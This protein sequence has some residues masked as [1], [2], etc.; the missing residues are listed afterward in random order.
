MKA[1]RIIISLVVLGVTL[2]GL[3]VGCS[4]DRTESRIA[5]V[6]QVSENRYIVPTGQILAS[7]YVCLDCVLRPWR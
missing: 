7:R 5:T 4:L 6:G 2:T 3:L 1:H